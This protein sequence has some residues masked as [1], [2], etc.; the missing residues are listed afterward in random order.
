MPHTDDGGS[1]KADCLNQLW[2]AL[3]RDE[4]A[5]G[6]AYKA[7]I[8]HDAEDA[9]HA[10][11]LRLFDVM[12]ER[13]DMV[14]LPVQ[15]L[16]NQH[17]KWIAGHYA[18]EFAESHGKYLSTREALGASVPS[19]GVGCAFMRES[20]AAIAT[21][22]GGSPF[23]PG[24]LTEDY[25]IGLHIR[26]MGGRT[27]FVTMRDGAGEMI[28]TEEH[29][30][31]TLD[32]AIK[33]KARWFVGISLAGWDRMGWHGGIREFWMRLH[34]RRTSLAALVL[35]AAYLGLLLYGLRLALGVFY[36]V[37]AEPMPDFLVSCLW[38]TSG[39]MLWRMAMR[40]FFVGRT[41]GLAQALRSVPRTF[42]ANIIAI[43]AARRAMG[44]YIRQLRGGSVVWDKT[45]H[46]S[47]FDTEIAA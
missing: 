40:A 10:D 27:A 23:D 29:F 26:Q 43:L 17:S 9:V 28:R 20:L 22:R 44:I 19:A 37:P 25:E 39:L 31:E 21:T 18:D 32:A 11:E 4:A 46:R 34:D 14:Q 2:G 35:C 16:L 12:T 1:T 41:Y 3:L 13:F 7:I 42:I 36:G 30:P 47:A 45:D 15:P 33:Q 6:F 8:L 24:S 5:E 38:I